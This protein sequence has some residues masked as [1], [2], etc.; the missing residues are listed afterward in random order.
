MSARTTLAP[1][2]T[3][4][5]LLVALTGCSDDSEPDPKPAVHTAANGDVYNDADASFASDLVQHHALSLTLVDLTRG[6]NVSPGLTA[7]ADEILAAQGPEIQSLT[8]WLTD[9]DQPAPETI[10]DHANAHADERGE[11]VEVPGDDLPGMPDH[12]ELEA[13]EELDG[14]E[15][16][17]RWLELMVAHHEGAIEIAEEESDAGRFS[18]ALD[19]ARAVVTTQQDQVEQMKSLLGD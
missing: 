6:R 3:A 16:E 19:L 4:V 14:P 9:W 12:A 11:V 2:A 17:Q 18:P 8:T 15:F 10:R 13:L 7:I 1:V 5:L